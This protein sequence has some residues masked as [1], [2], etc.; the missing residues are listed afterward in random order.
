VW[1]WQKVQGLLWCSFSSTLSPE[2]GLSSRRFLIPNDGGV[3]YR[4]SNKRFDHMMRH[5]ED[6]F[7]LRFNVLKISGRSAR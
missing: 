2:I 5:P 3:I 7:L 6:E 1:Q 4:M